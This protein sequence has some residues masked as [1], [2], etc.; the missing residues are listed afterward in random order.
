MRSAT[1]TPGRSLR[2]RRRRAA[3]TAGRSCRWPRACASA[4]SP[5]C[6][7]A[8]R[9]PSAC[10]RARAR[11]R[12]QRAPTPSSLP[13]IWRCCS[14]W[15]HELVAASRFWPGRSPPGDWP[16]GTGGS[17]RTRRGALAPGLDPSASSASR[18]SRL[19]WRTAMTAGLDVFDRVDG[20]PSSPSRPRS[21]CCL[22]MPSRSRCSRFS[23]GPVSAHR[24]GRVFRCRR[25]AHDSARRDRRSAA[26]LAL[27]VVP[28]RRP[29]WP[30][31][32]PTLTVVPTGLRVVVVAVDGVDVATLDRLRARDQVPVFDR[33]L[34]QSVANA[35]C[36]RRSRS[37]ARVDDDRD[38]VSRPSVTGPRRSKSRQVAGVGG[39][40]RRRRPDSG[41]RSSRA[42]DLVR[43]TRPSIASGDERL[44][45]AFWE[46]AARAGFR[47]AV[48]H[49]WATWPAP[50]DSGIVLSDRAILRLEHGG[51][52]R[53]QKSRP[54]SAVSRR[55]RS[56]WTDS[57]DRAVAWRS[58]IRPDRDRFGVVDAT[59]LGGA[60]RDDRRSGRRSVARHTRPAR[61]LPAGT[62]HRPAHAARAPER[63]D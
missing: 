28:L 26:R 27:L 48:V 7:S 47:T 50:D 29:G 44:I 62:R 53:W 45:P 5:A 13:C 46:V 18:I 59:T 57:R 4:Y 52:E 33:L 49:W 51:P 20:R 21:A 17:R 30:T 11:T 2:A 15:R 1:S 60:G 9:P 43:L 24:C 61:R 34:S 10:V 12:H 42:T 36:R 40:L 54:A 63:R 55:C 38:A 39:R 19:W 32:T 23:H 22:D 25:G 31:R 56:D 37:R 14:A 35:P 8:R 58:A 41:Q 3:T 6:C 16:R